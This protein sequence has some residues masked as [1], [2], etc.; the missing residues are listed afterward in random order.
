MRVSNTLKLQ[1]YCCTYLSISLKIVVEYINADG[2]VT[3][4]KRIGPVPSLRTKFT[5]LSYTR[6]EITQREQNALEFILT[7]THFQG[8]LSTER[9][10]AGKVDSLVITL[11]N[12]VSTRLRSRHTV[13]HCVGT[14]SKLYCICTLKSLCADRIITFFCMLRTTISTCAN[15]LQHCAQW[16]DATLSKF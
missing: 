1:S 6:V 4:V 15:Y 3:S 12:K 9:K 11:Q 13:D 2:Q 5:T 10:N 7:S 16:L 14:L 8:V